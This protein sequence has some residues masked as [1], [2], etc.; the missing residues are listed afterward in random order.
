VY[1]SG[2][3]LW[4]PLLGYSNIYSRPLLGNGSVNTFPLQPDQVTAAT[5]EEPLEAVFSVGSASQ[6]EPEPWNTDA[7][8]STTLG[9]VTRRQPVKTQQTEKT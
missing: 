9:A 6:R 5:V 7:E 4:Q 3:V 2:Y 8:E 1:A